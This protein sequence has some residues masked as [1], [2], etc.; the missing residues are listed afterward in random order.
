MVIGIGTDI[1][2][3]GRISRNIGNKAFMDRVF[4]CREQEYF[5]ER[6]WNPQ[7]I[8]GTFS[9]KEAVAKALGTGFRGFGWKD[10][11]ILR[12][13]LGKPYAVLHGGAAERMRSCEG[14]QIHLSISHV[15]EL[16]VAYSILEGRP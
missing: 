1:V 11:E 4:T 16:A 14:V 10:I 9:A 5:L 2:E 15:K 6:K 12:D 7:I 8:A 13:D 3:V